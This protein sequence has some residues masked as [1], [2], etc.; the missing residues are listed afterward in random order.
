MKGDVEW[1]T[2]THKW[3]SPD[4]HIWRSWMGVRIYMNICISIDIWGRRG[5]GRMG[6]EVVERNLTGSKRYLA[7]HHFD[8]RYRKW[9]GGRK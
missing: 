7:A 5:G 8:W 9:R 1:N 4:T 2:A 6:G 3:L